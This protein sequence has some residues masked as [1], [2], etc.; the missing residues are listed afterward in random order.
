MTKLTWNQQRAL[1][2]LERFP[3]GA[4]TRWLADPYAYFQPYLC[5]ASARSA[6]MALVAKG[7]AECSDARSPMRYRLTP[8]GI[9][10]AA[11]QEGR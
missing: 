5:G 9:A 3:D 7:L 1:Q 2:N 8:A 6:V 10:R 11:M 4:P